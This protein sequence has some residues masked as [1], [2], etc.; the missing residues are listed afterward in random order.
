MTKVSIVFGVL[1]LVAIVAIA[2][3]AID[4]PFEPNKIEKDMTSEELNSLAEVV[5]YKEFEGES[6]SA[7]DS[8]QTGT[9]VV[10]MRPEVP[11]AKVHR[12]L[13]NKSRLPEFS[14]AV[15]V[16]DNEWDGGSPFSGLSEFDE[17][18]IE[19]LLQPT[20]T[21]FAK[22]SSIQLAGLSAG[23]KLPADKWLPWIA[24]F[25]PSGVYEFR[26]KVQFLSQAVSGSE[27][28]LVQKKMTKGQK[29]AAVSQ[30]S[31]LLRSAKENKAGIKDVL[32]IVNTLEKFCPSDAALSCIHTHGVLSPFGSEA[33]EASLIE[34]L[35]LWDFA[36]V[37]WLASLSLSSKRGGPLKG[38][39]DAFIS[40]S[41]RNKWKSNSKTRD[42][43]TRLLR[44]SIPINRSGNAILY[45][46]LF[47]RKNLL[48]LHLEDISVEL[49]ARNDSIWCKAEGLCLYYECDGDSAKK[50]FYRWLDSGSGLELGAAAAAAQ[51]LISKLSDNERIV[52]RLYEIA[53]DSSLSSAARHAALDSISFGGK[54]GIEHGRELCVV[55]IR[56]ESGLNGVMKAW[57]RLLQRVDCQELRNEILSE[58]RTQSGRVNYHALFALSLV[59]CSGALGEVERVI[60][61]NLAYSSADDLALPLAT[62]WKLDRTSRHDVDALWAKITGTPSSWVQSIRNDSGHFANRP[63]ISCIE[64]FWIQRN[65][66]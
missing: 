28:S 60:N 48:E 13:R 57:G 16:I 17:A 26:A 44:E 5:S 66:G 52:T 39:T 21:N 50:T 43:L 23:M 46:L 37:E 18:K 38:I 58:V 4:E 47:T 33:I 8:P 45:A 61:N 1:I 30:I 63:E 34:L 51:K 25:E 7:C 22:L 42:S 40:V 35:S 64:W 36:D 62:I 6:V 19:G 55:L 32:E 24:E 14:D 9:S 27:Y 49:M 31:R 29:A 41:A 12:Q 10:E 59:N 11:R 54:V 56:S 3:V 15:S 20:E 2:V 53:I 65:R